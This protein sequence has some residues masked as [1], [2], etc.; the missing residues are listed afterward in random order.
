MGQFPKWSV[1]RFCPKIEPDIVCV[2]YG[3][4]ARKDRF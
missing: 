4:Y 1:H 3:N 2:F